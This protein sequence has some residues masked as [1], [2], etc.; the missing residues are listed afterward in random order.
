MADIR[1]LRG[2]RY[3]TKALGS[4][5][6]LR[7]VVSPPY[8]VADQEE[9][10]QICTR[11]EFNVM[12]LLRRNRVDGH[13]PYRYA[14]GEFCRWLECGVLRRDESPAVYV[15]EQEYSLVG[16]DGKLRQVKRLG[17]T[18]LVR[19]ADYSERVVLPHENTIQA[20]M[21][22]RFELM[23]AVNANL[24]S[25]FGI[26]DDDQGIVTGTINDVISTDPDSEFADY[27]DITHRTWLVTDKS[28][29]ARIRRG[30]ASKPIIIADGHHR[31]EAALRYRDYRRS[32]APV[33]D[34]DAPYEYTLMTFIP[35]TADGVDI[36]PTHRMVRGLRPSEVDRTI[37]Q[38]RRRFRF[39]PDVHDLGTV[40][41]AM[42]RIS[43]EGGVRVGVYT[44][45]HGLVVAPRAH[46]T[47]TL[48]VT[49]VE[50]SVMGAMLGSGVG[51][52]VRRARG[53]HPR[54]Q[55]GHGRGG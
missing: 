39:A 16:P 54:W 36:L 23:K 27:D 48:D 50:N 1:A 12:R 31:Y 5:A 40:L 28:F 41:E 8:D 44:R 53:V 34:P 52:R 24:S 3:D 20:Q 22:D 32:M 37:D 46:A 29:I 4:S 14:A 42:R 19:L 35:L 43:D 26:F 2:V 33:P 30:M 9:Q 7:E 13:L 17:F 25:V 6:S 51:R 45:K 18:A 47:G 10:E 21:Q 38:M 11:S 55:E 49:V 15:Y